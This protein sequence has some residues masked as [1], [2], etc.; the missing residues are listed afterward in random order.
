M[1]SFSIML[2]HLLS[3]YS[4]AGAAEDVA[5]YSQSRRLA[6][7]QILQGDLYSHNRVCV[8]GGG[9]SLGVG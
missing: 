5:V 8:C 1:E 7:V 4:F 9:L 2:T 6:V 3:S